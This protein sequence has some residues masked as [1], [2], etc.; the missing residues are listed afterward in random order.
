MNYNST[1]HRRRSIRLQRYDYS[2][3]GVYFI[4]FC[5]HNRLCLF[6]DIVDGQMYLND[7]G[8]IVVDEWTKTP[9]IRNEIILDK[10][11]VMPNHFHGIMIITND[12]FRNGTDTPGCIIPTLQGRSGGL[13][14]QGSQVGLVFQKGASGYSGKGD[15][16]VAPTGPKPRSI[17]AIMAGYKSAVTKRI[18]EMCQTPGMALWQRNYWEHVIRDE[19]EM[20]SLRQY[21]QNNPA[22]WESDKLYQPSKMDWC[23]P[24]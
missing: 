7:A 10:W 20:N 14:D 16:R 11:V 13:A 15:R 23:P 2:C 6:G 9:E 19:S 24:S 17:G 22:Q 1:I 18:N 3:A 5:T 21:V 8:R 4:T 12:T